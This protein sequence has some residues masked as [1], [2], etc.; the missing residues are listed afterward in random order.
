MG[1]GDQSQEIQG[2]TLQVDFL[3]FPVTC[4]IGSILLYSLFVDTANNS[5]DLS[6]VVFF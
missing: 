6:F 5:F 3:P 4:C 1:I 2:L